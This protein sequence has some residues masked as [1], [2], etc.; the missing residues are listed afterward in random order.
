MFLT[1]SETANS[2]PAEERLYLSEIMKIEFHLPF[3]CRKN[4]ILYIHHRIQA[5]KKYPA[6]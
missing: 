1:A 2:M 3:F 4:W 5:G 6:P